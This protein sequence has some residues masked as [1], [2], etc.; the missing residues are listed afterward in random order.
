M[1]ELTVTSHVATWQPR[2]PLAADEVPAWVKDACR[3]LGRR[4]PD[5]VAD[6][7]FPTLLAEVGE[8]RVDD[9]GVKITIRRS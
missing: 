1:F 9:C 8:W 7:E 2:R 6:P 4:V 3:M 5:A